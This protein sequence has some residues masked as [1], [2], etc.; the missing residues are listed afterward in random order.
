MQ[1]LEE[2]TADFNTHLNAFSLSGKVLELYSPANYLWSLGGK[3]IRPLLTLLAYQLFSN[4]EP[5][6]AYQAATAIELFHNFTLMHDDIMDASP[7]RRGKP[8][9]HVVYGTHAAILSGDLM[10]IKVY[11]LL[12]A[13]PKSQ[14]FKM[15][16]LMTQTAIKVCEGQQLD[17]NFESKEIVSETDYLQMIKYKTAVLLGAS[18]KMGGIAAG[19]GKEACKKLY[20]IGVR[21]GISFQ[22][23]DDYLDVYSNQSG[24]Q[25][26]GDII[27]KKKTL[28][29]IHAM[30]QANKMDRTEL[31]KLYQGNDPDK[32][33]L[34]TTRFDQNK[35][36]EYVLSLAKQY[37][38]QAFEDLD[39]ID[40]NSK[41]KAILRELIT[42]LL[43]RKS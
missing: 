31:Q 26:G 39:G 2:I 25:K 15:I 21:A 19:A 28:L 13:Y 23:I 20:S 37:S 10:L 32:V 42:D 36:S 40:C 12:S 24:K 18:L 9:T 41:S 22:L 5:V 27:Q 14:R 1:S 29:F 8:T 30:N 4:E 11:E 35:S 33:S 38:D 43:K 34:V 3:R 6:H 7:L 16:K 17:I